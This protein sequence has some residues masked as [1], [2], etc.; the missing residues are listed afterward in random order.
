[1]SGFSE[2]D[3]RAK[4]S[5]EALDSCQLRRGSLVL[6]VERALVREYPVGADQDDRKQPLLLLWVGK[7]NGVPGADV[8]TPRAAPEEYR[9]GD[10]IAAFEGVRLLER[11]LRLVT[12]HHLDLRLAENDQTVETEWHRVASQVGHGVASTAGFSAVDK[13]ALDLALKLLAKLDEDDLILRWSMPADTL[14]RE[15]GALTDSRALRYRLSTT[16][17]GPSGP[18]AELTL[19]FYLEPEPGC[20]AQVPQAM[21]PGSD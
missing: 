10:P 15:L 11:P 12:G 3:A 9:P 5:V 4:A 2:A 7:G 6:E 14:I 1:M 21:T 16:R 13:T 18:A 19:L 17:K 20:P 8:I